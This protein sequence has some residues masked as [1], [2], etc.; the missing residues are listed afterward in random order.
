VKHVIRIPANDS[1]I[2][3]I[4][5]WLTRP[6][7]RPNQKPVVWYKSFLYQA[8]SW[9]TA[10]QVAAEVE[11]HTGELFPRVGFLVTDLTLPSRAVVRFCNQRGAAEQRIR[12]GKQPVKMTRPSCHRL[13][14]NEV[15]LWLSVIA[16]NLG[17]LWRR[18][19]LPKRV[20]RWSLT[21]LHQ[22]LVKTGGRLVKRARC[23]RPLLAE[24]HLSRRLFA[25]MVGRMES[26][27]LP[28]G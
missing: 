28:A 4:A 16:D 25:A 12:E 15:R 8:G 19:A 5:E 17:N 11:H 9:K 21:G 6:V 1:L 2:R 3:G 24:G 20:D 23:Y 18:L 27:R 10:R 22:R 7:G 14:S 26:L 13:R